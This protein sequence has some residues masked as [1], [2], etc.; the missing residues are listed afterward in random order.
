MGQECIGVRSTSAL[1]S[2]VSIFVYRRFPQT[3]G[4]CISFIEGDI[5]AKKAPDN[6]AQSQIL[7]LS[8]FESPVIQLGLNPNVQPFLFHISAL[9]L[10]YFHFTVESEKVKHFSA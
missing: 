2:L 1:R 9:L 4:R 3:L 10:I 6:L 5:L 8:P 7:S